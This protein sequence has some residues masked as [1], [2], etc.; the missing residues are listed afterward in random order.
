MA[1]AE[2]PGAGVVLTYKVPAKPA[3]LITRKRTAASREAVAAAR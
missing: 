2:L 1:K 3:K